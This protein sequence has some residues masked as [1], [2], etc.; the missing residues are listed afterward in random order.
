MLARTAVLGALLNVR[1]NLQSIKD[2]TFVN[3]MSKQADLLQ[4]QTEDKERTL[5]SMKSFL[6]TP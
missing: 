3:Q 4:H 5:L 6:F 2:Q 1:I